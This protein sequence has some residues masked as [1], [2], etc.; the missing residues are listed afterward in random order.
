M[1][2]PQNNFRKQSQGSQSKLLTFLYMGSQKYPTSL[3]RYSN[4]SFTSPVSQT[5]TTLR[6]KRW[7]RPRFANS[8]NG[9]S[10]SS[11]SLRQAVKLLESWR[12]KALHC[13]T[14]KS[15]STT[16]RSSPMLSAGEGT[17]TEVGAR[18]GPVRG[19]WAGEGAFSTPSKRPSLRV[20]PCLAPRK[21]NAVNIP[22]GGGVRQLDTA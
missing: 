4:A 19:T 14:S 3:R 11:W 2:S 12:P 13:V 20:W 17:R 7:M 10:A 22:P 16:E 15:V 5:P 1:G 9:R 21:K 8:C 6:S 18:G